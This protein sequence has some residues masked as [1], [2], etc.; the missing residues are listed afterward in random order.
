MSDFNYYFEDYTEEEKNNNE[1]LKKMSDRICGNLIYEKDHLRK[2]YNYYNGVM[3]K[4][5]YKYLEDTYGI[6]SPTSIEFIPLV[7][8]HIDSLI[9]QHLSNKVRPK[10]TCKDKDTLTN[11]FK[12]KQRKIYESEIERLKSSL[13]DSLNKLF[14]PNYR[15]NGGA[16]EE[17]LEKLKSDINKD[18]ISE[19]EEAAQYML[20]F[21]VQ[22]RDINLSF[23]LKT[24]FLDMLVAGQCYYEV[25]IPGKGETPDIEVLNPFDVFYERDYDSPFVKDSTKVVVRRYLSK[26]QIISK[27]GHH[28]SKEDIDNINH[29]LV[30]DTIYNQN[31][32]YVRTESGGL[33]SNLGVTTTDT[34]DDYNTYMFN[35]L[36]PVY[37]IEWL[38]NNKYKDDEGNTKY[39][40]DR[41]KVIK[42]G[43]DIYICLGKD[44]NVVRSIEHPDRCQVSVGGVAY[45]NRN[46][47]P[48]SLVLATANLQDRHICPV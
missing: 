24:L 18:F 34:R 43:D 25:S 48:F 7:K 10:I 28:L 19:Y 32:M 40:T 33:I 4:D 2:A 3:D 39:R 45:G 36:Y 46:G 35:N 44:E 42:I 47:A 9:G 38:S 37:E 16:S 26:Q 29:K 13:Y 15:T 30:G 31:V 21:F 17:E 8:R 14:D 11:I 22:N 27:Y 20:T 6:G 41:Y 1:Y 5:Q 23:K 12:E